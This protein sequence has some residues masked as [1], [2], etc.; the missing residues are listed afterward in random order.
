MPKLQIPMIFRDSENIYLEFPA[1][2]DGPIGWVRKFP[3]AEGG[4]ALLKP[5]DIPTIEQH[6][7]YTANAARLIGIGQP[8]PRTAKNKRVANKYTKEEGKELLQKLN[9]TRKQP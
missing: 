4:L 7:G 9:L 3:I 5:R 8:K 6:P 1:I 2:K